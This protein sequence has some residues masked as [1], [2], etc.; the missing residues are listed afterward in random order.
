MSMKISTEWYNISQRKSVLITIWYCIKWWVYK[1]GQLQVTYM[2]AS[3]F[4]H[5]HSYQTKHP[6]YIFFVNKA[7]LWDLIA[8]TCLVMLLQLYSNC[9]FFGLYDLEIRW[10]TFKNNMAPV[11]VKFCAIFWSHQWIQVRKHQILVKI[12]EF[13]VPCELQI[14]RWPWKRIWYLLYATSSFMHHFTAIGEI[15]LQLQSG[16][17]QFWSNSMVLLSHLTLKFIEWPWKT[18]RLLYMLLQALCIIP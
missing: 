7:N 6:M 8:P 4:C 1:T 14:W 2:M 17:A 11:H 15:K 13:C 3:L 5:S 18:I 10:M 12:S 9:W 16:D